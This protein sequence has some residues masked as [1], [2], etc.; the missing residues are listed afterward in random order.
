MT[1]RFQR[2][3]RATLATI[4]F[5]V[6]LSYPLF[7]QDSPVVPLFDRTTPL[8]PLT[9]EDTPEARITRIGDRV[10]DRHARESEFQA[11]DHYLSFYWEQRTVSLELIDKVAKGG[12]EIVVTIKSLVPLNEPNFRSF[13]RGVNTVA[14]YHENV[15]ASK[16]AP[17]TYNLTI[18]H[19][20]I[21]KRPLKIGDKM[22]FEFSPFLISPQ[23][24]RNN[25]YG[26]TML[27]VVGQGIV[28]WMGVGSRLDSVP[29]PESAR[30]GGATSLSY[31]YSKEP[32]ERFKQMAG[33]IAPGSAQ[34]FLLG[35][36]LH[37]TNMLDGT[38]CELRKRSFRNTSHSFPARYEESNR[39]PSNRPPR[40]SKYHSSTGD[41]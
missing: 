13:F 11:Y 24:G 1:N 8:E 32:S 37:H 39:T 41:S 19:H 7:A 2:T 10:R 4:G 5:T 40:G 26:T 9:T 18:A 33:N 20:P 31:Q 17:N 15:I 34:P 14:E 3:L 36:R 16:I 27:Y 30:L 6:G 21:E 29:L 38:H 23:H 28:P 35:R 25:Y 22:E 12:Q